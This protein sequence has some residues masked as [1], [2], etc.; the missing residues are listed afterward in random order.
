MTCL[1]TVLQIHETAADGTVTSR[2]WEMC[3]H[4]TDPLAA[5]LGA[6]DVSWLATPQAHAAMCD[7]MA[8]TPGVVT[9]ARRS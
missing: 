7:V 5:E 8:S 3:S 1:P 4:V 6:A 2:S 9:H